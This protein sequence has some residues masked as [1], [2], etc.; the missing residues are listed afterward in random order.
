MA[1]TTTLEALERDTTLNP[2]QLRAAGFTP[3]TIYGGKKGGSVSI[4]LREKVT[5]QH[6]IH[7]LREFTLSN[8][9]GEGDVRV[10]AHQ[11]QVDPIKQQILNIEFLRQGA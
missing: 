7:G 8:V 10:K 11:I 1:D 3:A 6:I 9:P 5:H 4:Q 2:R